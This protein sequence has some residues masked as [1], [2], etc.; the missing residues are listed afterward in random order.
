MAEDNLETN[1]ITIK[2]QTESYVT[3]LL[4]WVPSPSCSPPGCPFPIKSLALSSDGSTQTIHFWVLD[5]SPVSGPGRGPLSYNK[6]STFGCCLSGLRELFAASSSCKPAP[7]VS[8]CAGAL[9]SPR[10]PSQQPGLAWPESLPWVPADK[11]LSW[12]CVN[13]LPL[14]HSP[15]SGWSSPLYPGLRPIQPGQGLTPLLREPWHGAQY[16][17]ESSLREVLRKSLSQIKALPSLHSW[18]YWID[19]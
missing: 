10:G 14:P 5:K 19:V 6:T 11:S 12:L 18:E 9:S 13:H 8:P 7:H 3:E 2:P 4:S 15:L 16:L 17:V 1:P